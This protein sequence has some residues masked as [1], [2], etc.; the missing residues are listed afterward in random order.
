M[1][2]QIK[3]S[4]DPEYR[5]VKSRFASSIIRL[6]FK[7]NPCQI[8]FMYLIAVI[9]IVIMVFSIYLAQKCQIKGDYSYETFI[10]INVVY[11]QPFSFF[12]Q[13]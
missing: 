7:I 6:K 11:S 10:T 3:P 12:P 8:V 9:T 2:D 1:K 4:P 5:S 13:R